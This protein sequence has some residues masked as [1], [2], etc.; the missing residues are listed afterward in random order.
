VQIALGVG[1]V[2]FNALVYGGFVMKKR[3]SE[4]LLI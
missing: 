1:V 2:V 3:N 4:L